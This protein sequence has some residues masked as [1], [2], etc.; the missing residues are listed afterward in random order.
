MYWQSLG[1]ELEDPTL[2]NTTLEFDNSNNLY[3]VSPII[4]LSIE[5]GGG[6]RVWYGMEFWEGDSV[7]FF[8]TFTSLYHVKYCT[9]HLAI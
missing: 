6:G 2:Q 3:L 1:L 7:I 8:E 9:K 4:L 5:G